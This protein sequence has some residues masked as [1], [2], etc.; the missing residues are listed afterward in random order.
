MSGMAARLFVCKAEY[1]WLLSD[2]GIVFTNGEIVGVLFVDKVEGTDHND[3]DVHF[4][5]V[6]L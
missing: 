5:G 1:A 4:H 2:K 6:Q 3:I